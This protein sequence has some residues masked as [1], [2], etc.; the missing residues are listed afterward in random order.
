MWDLMKSPK[1]GGGPEHSEVGT[2]TP[3]VREVEMGAG[4]LMPTQRDPQWAK[5][6][7]TSN[8]L[9]ERKPR[10]AEAK[11]ITSSSPALAT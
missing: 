1:W 2:P 7:H 4:F 6:S 5:A 9:N 8:N 11:G 10:E 3:G